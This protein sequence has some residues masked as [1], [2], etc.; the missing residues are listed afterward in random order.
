VGREA[1]IDI[2]DRI[3]WQRSQTIE[4]AEDE[5]ARYL[6][7]AAFAEGRLDPDE[8]E[9]VAEWLRSHKEAADDIAATSALAGAETYQA[10]SETV[11]ARA[12]AIV[13][14]AG[15]GRRSSV[16]PFRAR[17]GKGSVLGAAAQWGGLAAALVVAG[18]LGFT[19][20]MDTSGII[21]RNGPEPDDG[22]TQELLGS[23]PGFF[24]DMT[25]GA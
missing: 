13:G 23:S 25:G 4:A 14:G 16:V 9:R 20:G 5:C 7:L 6:D 8:R 17:A 24:R 3:L 15:P 2:A 10:V 18:W 19:L 21:A 11:V 12:C 22:I 1:W